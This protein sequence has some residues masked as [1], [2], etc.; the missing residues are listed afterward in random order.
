MNHR[1]PLTLILCMTIGATVGWSTANSET[2]VSNIPYKV[3]GILQYNDQ[4]KFS[5]HETIQNRHR[6]IRLN[7]PF[8]LLKLKSFDPESGEIQAVFQGENISLY[9]AKSEESV[10]HVE[11]QNSQQQLSKL[12]IDHLVQ[13]FEQHEYAKLPAQDSPVYQVLHQAASNRIISFRSEL[14]AASDAAA[15]ANATL[16]KDDQSITGQTE[17]SEAH[18]ALLRNAIRPNQLNSRIWASDHIKH[19]GT[20]AQIN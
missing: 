7:Q 17:V 3:R 1:M 15:K 14:Q 2:N 5:I 4:L 11:I 8:G 6:W 20:P 16:S 18:P 12:E 19:H 13:Q 9:L 10:L